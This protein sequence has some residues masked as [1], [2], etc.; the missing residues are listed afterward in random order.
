[1]G[2]IAARNTAIAGLESQLDFENLTDDALAELI[3]RLS[4]I[5]AD[6]AQ[7]GNTEAGGDAGQEND[8]EAS[9]AE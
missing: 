7:A 8:T 1:M 9:D 2:E 6:R 5:Q 3:E 4:A